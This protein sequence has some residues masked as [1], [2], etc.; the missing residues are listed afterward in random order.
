M[1][2]PPSRTFLREIV[3]C[4]PRSCSLVHCGRRKLS[5]DEARK[6]RRRGQTDLAA[7]G[8]VAPDGSFWASSFRLTSV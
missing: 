6:I 2:P 4:Y 1:R 3:G 7:R 5:V 8:H